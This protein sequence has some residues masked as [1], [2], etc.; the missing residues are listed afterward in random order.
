LR[1]H[2][3][4]QA[5]RRLHYASFV[6]FWMAIVHGLGL[7]TE[8]TTVWA[9][10]LYLGTAAPVTFLSLYRMLSTPRLRVRLV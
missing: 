7:G 6:A 4:G 2:L 10:L 9:S 3:G 8:S 1:R 5:W